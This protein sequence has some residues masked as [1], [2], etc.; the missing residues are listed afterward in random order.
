[1]ANGLEVRV[2]FLDAN[3]ADYALGLPA[4]MVARGGETKRILKAALRGTVPDYVLDAP[5]TG[6]GVPYGEWLATDLHDY[7]RE[8]LTDPAVARWG[9]F[10]AARIDRC[11]REHRAGRGRYG[12]LLWKALH[13]AL[14]YERRI[15]S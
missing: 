9:V 13:L 5:K 14:W 2:P 1:M 6:F 15:A 8:V 3:I 7:M 11:M 10:D 12:F 4:D